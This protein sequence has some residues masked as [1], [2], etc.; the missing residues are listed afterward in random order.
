V[1][2]QG[3]VYVLS[4]DNAF[5]EGL[6][7][8]LVFMNS[9]GT[10]E[11][12]IV[13]EPPSLGRVEISLSSGTAGVEATFRVDN[14]QLK[15]MVNQQLEALKSSLEAQGIHVSGLTVDI[16]N[17]DGERG[18][19]RGNLHSPKSRRRAGGI[20]EGTAE[21]GADIPRVIRLDLERGILH[22]VA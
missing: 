3:E 13:V 1:F 5:G 21:D 15:Y 8:V 20:D 17:G 4:P 22:W 16:K 6:S 9:E 11:A 19:G 2:R 10:T 7:S 18:S 12:R 14:E